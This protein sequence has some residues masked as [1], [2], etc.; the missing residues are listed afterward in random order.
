M[1]GNGE[2]SSSRCASCSVASSQ[3][4]ARLDVAD[5]HHE[6]VGAALD[7]AQQRWQLPTFGTRCRAGRR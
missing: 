6:A 4:T 3:R 7:F 5:V 1:S 2:P